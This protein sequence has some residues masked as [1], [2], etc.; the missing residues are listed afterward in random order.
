MS[1][2]QLASKVIVNEAEPRIRSVPAL[3]TAMWVAVGV[4]EKGPH[5]A[6][7]I[8]SWEEYVNIFGGFTTDAKDLPSA[9][10][11]FFA[12]G[13]QFCYVIRIVHY[14]NV[15]DKTTYTSA[16]ATITLTDRANVPVDTLQIDAISDGAWGNDITA[17]IT[18]ATS[19]ESTRFNLIVKT[20]AGV[21]LETWANL[22]MIDADSRYV[23]S[24]INH[25]VT[26]SQY[27]RVTDL[28]SATVAPNDMPAIGSTGLAGGANGLTDLADTDFLGSSA[29]GTGL[30]RLEN[31]TDFTLVSIPGRTSSAIQN[32]IISYLAAR[33]DVF[34]FAILDPPASTTASGMITY[35]KS[36][37]SLYNT[38]EL[39][40]IYWPRIKVLNP[41][42]T[43]YG[44]DDTLTVPPCG[45]VAG[46]Y[47]R[48]DDLPG[49]IYR[50]PA[51]I[52]RGI[53]RSAQGLEMEEVKQEAKRDLVYPTLVN[54]ITTIPG[55]PIHI[56]GSRTL[57]ENGNFP[58]VPERRGVLFIESSIWSLMQVFRHANNTPEVRAQA[59]RSVT[60]FLLEQMNVGAFR[61]RD[62]NTAF[63]V[64]FGEGLN[65]VA[66]QRQKKL[67]GRIGLATATPID[68]VELEFSQDT[69]ALENEIAA[70]TF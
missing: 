29:G 61:T 38:T 48:T 59:D 24:I 43:V 30:W 35:I 45:H 64:D 8:T 62:P 54:P 53:I 6:T 28:D 49:G 25:A 7:L 36:T 57:K 46:V 11:G 52:E 47:A 37:V 16:A 65:T 69:R 66:V 60:A 31:V 15:A 50:A 13:G 44:T 14:S 42:K 40:A 18:A 41:D 34:A 10:Q 39:A 55:V 58:S 23:E 3:R 26:G 5:T 12:E 27:I 33:T 1:K 20:D 4:A 2:A 9:V 21:V 22:S 17:Q 63:F 19:G 67:K 32:G 68:Y 56:D 70:A 51:G